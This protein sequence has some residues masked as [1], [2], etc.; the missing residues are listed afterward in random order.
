MPSGADHEGMAEDKTYFTYRPAALLE[1]SDEDA[2]DFL[3]SQFSNDLR[4]FAADRCVYGLWLNV[5]G[6]VVADS[7][8]LCLGEECFHLLSAHCAGE[9][10]QAHLERHVVADDVIIRALPAGRVFELDAGALG[11]L[12]L[13]ALQAG[14][15]A[16]VTWGRL[17]TVDGVSHQLLTEKDGLS[18]DLGQR[19]GAA[20]YEPLSPQAHARR[21]LEQ[22]RP[23]VPLELGP[24][25][26]PGE[27]GMVG[28]GVS[29]HKG[30]FLGQE[31]VARMHNVGRAQRQL[32]R[33]EGQGD[34]PQLG[35]EVVT[36]EGKSVGSLR[37]L[38]DA[39]NDWF[40]VAM[41]KLRYLDPGAELRAEGKPLRV[42]HALTR[43]GER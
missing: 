40:G 38:Y 8:V 3:Q 13:D 28:H 10:I 6:R 36:A 42:S 31:V 35:A 20:G 2:A 25:D 1:V 27:A 12:E 30:C 34:C 41:L 32:F 26:L 15:H 16:A 24:G 5:K 33:V 43:G 22:G 29:L 7:T 21:R 39:G 18:E 19:L 9:S 23:E 14:Q 11:V 37:S 4:P 17:W